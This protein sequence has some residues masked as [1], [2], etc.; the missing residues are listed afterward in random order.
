LERVDPA[1]SALL[2]A[3]LRCNIAVYRIVGGD[4]SAGAADVLEALRILRDAQDAYQTAI[5]LQHVALMESL[6]GSIEHA[7][8]ITGYIDAFLAVNAIEHDTT[9]FKTRR[10]IEER[11]RAQLT[12]KRYDELMGCGAALSE[13]EIVALA[14]ESAQVM[15]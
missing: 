9:E 7:A 14:E 3:N 8:I 13:P 10:L 5:A 6:C 12:P 11:L 1:R 4:Y 15:R 2:A